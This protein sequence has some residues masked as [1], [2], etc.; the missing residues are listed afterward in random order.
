MAASVACGQ[1]SLSCISTAKGSKMLSTGIF[2]RHSLKR[3][4]SSKIQ[5][6]PPPSVSDSNANRWRKSNTLTV[7]AAVRQLTGSIT[8]PEGLRFVVVAARFNDIITKPLVDGALEG[9]R[10]HS[11]REEDVDVIWV[12]GSFEIP[13]VAQTVAKSGKYHAVICIGAVVRGATTHY[14]AVANSASSGVLSA[15]LNSGSLNSNSFEGVPCIFGV[16]TCDTMEQA[17]DRAGGKVGNK[18]YEAAVTACA[19]HL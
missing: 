4:N 17:M 15:G 10:R 12:P 14:E 9:F 8:K 1:A 11:V 7:Y 2:A 6:T 3:F 5:A 19:I 13:L 18:G 16:L